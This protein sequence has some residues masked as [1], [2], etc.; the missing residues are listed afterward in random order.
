MKAKCIIK[1]KFKRFIYY[2]IHVKD[3][4]IINKFLKEHQ[5]EISKKVMEECFNML[6]GEELLKKQ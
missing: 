1:N 6:I 4:I 2:L 3:F 5:N